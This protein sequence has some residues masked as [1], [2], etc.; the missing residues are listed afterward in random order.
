[1]RPGPVAT[2]MMN[3]IPAKARFKP[4][5]N[6]STLM[7]TLSSFHSMMWCSKKTES[8]APKWISATGTISP[9]TWQVLELKWISVMSRMRGAS[10]Q[11]DSLTKLRTSSGA[12]HVIHVVV[13]G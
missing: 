8:L 2:L 12:P 13:P 6:C 11:P 1:M 4:P 10:R 7:G 9:S 3:G 5:G